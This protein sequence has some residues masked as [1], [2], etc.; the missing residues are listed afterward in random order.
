MI[1]LTRDEI[2]AFVM[3]SNAIEGIFEPANHPLVVNHKK[4]VRFAL[5]I[6]RKG[7]FADP[8]TI[9]RIIM[10]SEWYKRPGQY[11]NVG[12]TIGRNRTPPPREIGKLMVDLLHSLLDGLKP[13]ENIEQWI[14]DIHHE[15]ECIH[16][17]LDGNGRTGRI[18][19]NAIRV[20]YDLPWLT[21]FE[22][23]KYDYYHRID[24]FRWENPRYHQYGAVDPAYDVETLS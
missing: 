7:I 21:I 18:W 6:A 12:V 24:V 4:A 10:K 22:K 17:F 20:F 2:N 23:E 11:R 3:E 1:Y 5:K 13:E 16:P 9:H 15:F 8:L 19:M 14:W